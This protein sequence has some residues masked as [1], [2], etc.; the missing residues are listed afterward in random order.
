MYAKAY[1]SVSPSDRYFLISSDE[2]YVAPAMKI[3]AR[4]SAV[5]P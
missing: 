5:A 3:A 2:R 4:P 1:P